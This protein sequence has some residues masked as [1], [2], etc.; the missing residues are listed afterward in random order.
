LSPSSH[1]DIC[2]ILPG[3][4]PASPGETSTGGTVLGCNGAGGASDSPGGGPALPSTNNVLGTWRQPVQHSAAIS[5]PGRRTSRRI[6][7]PRQE[8]AELLYYPKEEIIRRKNLV[9]SW[10]RRRIRQLEERVKEMNHIYLADQMQDLVE[11]IENMHIDTDLLL[12]LKGA[13]P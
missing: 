7:H 1:A 4:Y 9:I 11:D 8:E 12:Q 13:S 2:C 3:R 10:Q 5:E 6:T